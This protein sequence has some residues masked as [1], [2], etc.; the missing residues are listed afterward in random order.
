MTKEN[1][2]DKQLIGDILDAITSIENFL[3]G[4]TEENFEESYMI[5]S[6]VF[7]QFEII[8]E[9]AS[10]LSVAITTNHKDVE[11]KKIVGIRHKMIHDYFE[12][13]VSIVWDTA[14]KQI[15]ILKSQIEKVNK[16][17]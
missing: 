12:V 3:T 4:V 9:A 13:S 11:W 6:A 15:P 10:K 2:T 8:G 16:E 5:Q 1:R 17:L 7:R 14:Q